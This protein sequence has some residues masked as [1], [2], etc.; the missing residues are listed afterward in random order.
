V[1]FVLLVLVAWSAAFGFNKMLHVGDQ[2][3]TSDVDT[4]S[5]A[6]QRPGP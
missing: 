4:P 3:P 1:A 5:T 2:D 6:P